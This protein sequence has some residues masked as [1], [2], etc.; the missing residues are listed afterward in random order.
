MKIVAF[1]QNPWSPPGTDKRHVQLYS[2]NQD[3]HR[4]LL[5]G[6]MSG[7]R[8]QQAF[9]SLFDTIWWDNA[10]PEAADAPEG[11]TRADSDHIIRVLKEQQP[12]IVITFGTMAKEALIEVIGSTR[13]LR[14]FK[15]PHLM[16]CHHPNARYRTQQDL[17]DF[18]MLVITK[19]REIMYAEP[20]END[21]SIRPAGNRKDDRAPQDSGG[22]D[23]VGDET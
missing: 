11:K 2:T 19:R 18:A 1:M 5:R 16:C 23:S 13:H 9:G 21:D 7:N 15:S 10:S 20:K 3:F 12:D 17:N 6:T 4:R 22:R 8:L 14:A